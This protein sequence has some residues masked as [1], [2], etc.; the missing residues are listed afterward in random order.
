MNIKLVQQ[1]EIEQ[2]MDIIG[3][4]ITIMRQEGSDQWDES[5]PTKERFLSDIDA[6]NLYGA[7]TDDNILMGFVCINEEQSKEYEAF[8]WQKNSY[9]A[10]HR[11]AVSPLYR[12]RSGI[13]KPAPHPGRSASP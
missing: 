9:M 12:G 13:A 10:V 6:G 5:Y 3:I 4:S 2:V 1:N 8:S 11:M 7:Y